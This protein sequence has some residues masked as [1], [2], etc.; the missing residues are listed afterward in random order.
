MNP[1]FD[2]PETVDIYGVLTRYPDDE[3]E[4]ETESIIREDRRWCIDIVTYMNMR[5]ALAVMYKALSPLL[6]LLIVRL[7]CDFLKH[8]CS[9]GRKR[10]K[11]LSTYLNWLTGERKA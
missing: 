11:H 7:T 10:D 9:E 8:L 1:F 5:V 2:L 6:F 4:A 3:T